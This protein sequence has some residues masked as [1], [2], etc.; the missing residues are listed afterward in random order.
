[1]IFILMFA[2]AS[3]GLTGGGLGVMQSPLVSFGLPA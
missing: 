1:L 3:A 2:V